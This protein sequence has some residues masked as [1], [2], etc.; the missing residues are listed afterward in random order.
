MSLRGLV[1]LRHG[2]CLY[3]DTHRGKTPDMTLL[4]LMRRLAALPLGSTGARSCQAALFASR[5]IVDGTWTAF[6]IIAQ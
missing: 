1:V 4:A 5:E 2:C 3:A 6:L